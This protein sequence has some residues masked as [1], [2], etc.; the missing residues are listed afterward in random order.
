[1]I[2]LIQKK[3]QIRDVTDSATRITLDGS[4]KV[5]IGDTSP[6]AK[7]HVEDT[8]WSSGAPYGAVAYIQGGAVNDLNWGHL[9]IVTIR[10]YN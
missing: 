2:S 10:H 6:F 8:G 3:F 1:M 5:G 4:G 9:L 7:L